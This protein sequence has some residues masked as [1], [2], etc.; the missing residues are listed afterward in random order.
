MMKIL[1]ILLIHLSFLPS[2]ASSFIHTS[3][4]HQSSVFGRF[5]VRFSAHFIINYAFI[6]CN[7]YTVEKKS[8]NKSRNKS[9]L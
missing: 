9:F 2:R 8:S 3:T 7:N 1:E 6:R 4:E 5:W